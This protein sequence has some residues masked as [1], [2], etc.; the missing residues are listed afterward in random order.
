MFL[1]PPLW[2]EEETI[3]IGAVNCRVAQ[4][5]RLVLLRLVVER[6]YGRRGRIHSKGVAF[7]AEQIDVAAPQQ[8]RVR[9]PVR[10]VAG[11]ASFGLHRRVLES[12]RSS[13]VSVAVEAE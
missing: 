13:L 1:S 10:L 9:R 4:R 7:Q 6:R 5:A 11:H 2:L 12:E 8:A 3:G